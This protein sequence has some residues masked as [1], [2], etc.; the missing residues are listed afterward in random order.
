[1]TN[2]RLYLALGLPTLVSSGTFI[3][4]VIAWINGNKRV[5]DLKDSL[6][7]RIDDLKSIVQ[8]EAAATRSEFRAAREILEEKIKVR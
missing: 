7:K 6:N 2:A 1:M 4:T 3:L 8:S 5:D